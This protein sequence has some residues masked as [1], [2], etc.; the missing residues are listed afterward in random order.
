MIQ[1]NGNGTGD[2][3]VMQINSIWIE[4]LA[5]YAHM[6]APAVADRLLNDSCFNIAAAA[7]I[8]RDSAASSGAKS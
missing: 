3:G 4:P 8:V 2:L 1:P 7:A 6:T 5:R